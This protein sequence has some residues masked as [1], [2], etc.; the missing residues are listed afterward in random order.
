MLPEAE[1]AAGSGLVV[2]LLPMSGAF[3]NGGRLG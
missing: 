3:D 2:I 1:N